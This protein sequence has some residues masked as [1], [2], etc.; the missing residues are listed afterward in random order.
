MSASATRISNL[1]VTVLNNMSHVFERGHAVF[2][3]IDFECHDGRF[4]KIC[5]ERQVLCFPAI[6]ATIQHINAFSTHDTQHPPHTRCREK[7]R[8]IVNDNGIGFLD[9]EF[10]DLLREKF[11]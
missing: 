9:T 11:R 4:R 5:F 2:L 3:E 7:S 10:A 8:A 1:L 6:Q